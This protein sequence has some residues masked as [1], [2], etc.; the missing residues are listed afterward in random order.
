MT[1]YRFLCLGLSV[2]TA[3]IMNFTEQATAASELCQRHVDGKIWR[4]DRI[5]EC[6]TDA[7]PGWT[8]VDMNPR[9][10]TIVAGA[11]ALFQRHVD[12]KKF[13]NTMVVESVLPVL[14][15]GGHLSI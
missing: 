11:G 7:C 3:S 9:T 5:G 4:Y 1:Q 6:S 10:E 14:A 8:L 12:G 15:R 13:S 2:V